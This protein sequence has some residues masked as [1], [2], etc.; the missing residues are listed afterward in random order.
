MKLSA[1]FSAFLCLSI[2]SF[3]NSALILP[4]GNALNTDVLSQAEY[5]E[6]LAKE[7]EK[8]GLKSQ[9]GNRHGSKS[10]ETSGFNHAAGFGGQ[11]S[12][13]ADEGFS[14]SVIYPAEL[15]RLNGNPEK[16]HFDEIDRNDFNTFKRN[17]DEIDRTAFNA[18]K[19][20]LDEIDRTGFNAFKRNFDEIDRAGFGGFADKRNIDE[21]DRAGFGGF[22]RKRNF[23]EIDRS[24]VPGFAK[25]SAP[26]SSSPNNNNKLRR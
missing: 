25:R 1:V 7:L 5:V 2:T 14:E 15:A 11:R 6:A 10:I 18:F 20:N 19:R 26:R 12:R 17:I 23:D 4:H 16:R 24:G 8:E 9:R 3:G 13:L 22:N 21:I